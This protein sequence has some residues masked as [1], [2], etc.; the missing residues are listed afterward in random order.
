MSGRHPLAPPGSTA[1]RRASVRRARCGC[2]SARSGSGRP[3]GASCSTVRGA[4]TP[5]R[6]R[7]ERRGAREAWAGPVPDRALPRAQEAVDD[8]R[9]EN[10]SGK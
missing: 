5:T 9:A 2:G 6:Y 10:G 3:S 1:A 4:L 7:L 8:R